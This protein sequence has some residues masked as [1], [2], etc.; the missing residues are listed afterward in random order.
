MNNRRIITAASVIVIVCTAVFA[1]TM[2]IYLL[3]GQS[4][5][6]G[7]GYI[8]NIDSEKIVAL[9]PEFSRPFKADQRVRLFYIKGWFDSPWGSFKG[10][11]NGKPELAWMPL[12]QCSEDSIRFGPEMGFGNRMMQQNPTDTIG[13][14]KYASSGSN[15]QVQWNPGTSSTDTTQW[16][17]QFKWFVKAVDSGLSALRKQGITPVIRGMLWQQGESDTGYDNYAAMLGHF[18]DR[19]RGQWSVPNM[20]F[21]YGYVYPAVPASVIRQAEHDVAQGSGTKYAKSNAYVVWTQDLELRRNDPWLPDAGL[22]TDSVHLGT[23]GQL[24]LGRRMADTV[25]RRLAQTAI[26]NFSAAGPMKQNEFSIV[27]GRDDLLKISFK[28]AAAGPVHID[29]YNLKGERIM[30]TAGQYQTPGFPIRFLTRVPAYPCVYI[31]VIVSNNAECVERRIVLTS[32]DH[33]K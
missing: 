14:I 8:R 32:R 4:N 16:G 6:T 30:R 15:L 17:T 5:A 18:I 12:R 33:Y 26:I 24:E 13:I 7:Q 3:G 22:S 27:A 19:V 29:I 28:L 11:E 31:A 9:T 10:L 1:R 2:D 25:T 23:A 20:L 21:V